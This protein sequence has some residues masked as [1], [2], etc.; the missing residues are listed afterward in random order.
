MKNKDFVFL[1][2]VVF[3][4]FMHEVLAQLLASTFQMYVGI[5]IYAPNQ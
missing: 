4:F 2:D 1:G 3:Q 5:E